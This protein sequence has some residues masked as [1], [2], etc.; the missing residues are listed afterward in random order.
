[1]ITLTEGVEFCQWLEPQLANHGAHCALMGSVLYA[2]SSE[3][4]LDIIV[5]SHDCNTHEGHNQA[6]LAEIIYKLFPTVAVVGNERYPNDRLVLRANLYGQLR[7]EFF[8]F[9]TVQRK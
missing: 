7:V 2:G 6:A 8:I 9:L 4:D 5:Y 1:M 3:K